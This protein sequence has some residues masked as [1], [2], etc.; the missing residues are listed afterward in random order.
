[1]ATHLNFAKTHPVQRVN[2]S[3]LHRGWLTLGEISCGGQ[4]IYLVRSEAV[5]GTMDAGNGKDASQEEG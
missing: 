4:L 1:M 5:H 2:R 3:Y